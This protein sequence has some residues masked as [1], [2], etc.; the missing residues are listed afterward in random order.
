MYTQVIASFSI[1]VNK[2]SKER[3]N[4]VTITDNDNDDSKNSKSSNSYKKTVNLKK[5]LISKN[6]N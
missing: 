2:T 3:V 4:Q 1:F 5:K 6:L